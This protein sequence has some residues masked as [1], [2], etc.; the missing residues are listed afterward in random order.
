MHRWEDNIR[1]NIKEMRADMK[2]LN[3]S[4]KVKDNYRALM[5]AAMNLRVS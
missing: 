5:N 1:I 4:A 3:C 2:N